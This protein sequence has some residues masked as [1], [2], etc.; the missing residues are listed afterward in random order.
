[1]ASSTRRA[2]TTLEYTTILAVVLVIGLIV[3]GLAMFFGQ[4]AGDVTQTEAQTYWASQAQP[5]RITAM[6]GYYY[7]SASTNGEVA[8]VIENVD[9][10]PITLM[11]L[12][13]EPN[14]GSDQLFSAYTNHSVSGA[15]GTFWGSSSVNSPT[16]TSGGITIVPNQKL[17]I[18]V[19][20]TTLCSTSSSASASTER[21]K[22]YL[23]LYYQTR[24][25]TGLSFRGTKP[26]MGR[27]NQ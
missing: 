11:G 3:I 7:T 10:K 19:R 25:F 14:I 2:Q 13:F 21:F 8:L 5:L 9:S 6:Q 23:T 1:M 24:D 12:V 22:N 26:I 20:A 27:C 18:F 4:S 15:P 16:W 17:S